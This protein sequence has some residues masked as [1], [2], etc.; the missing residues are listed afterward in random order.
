MKNETLVIGAT[1]KTDRY[2]YRAIKN[3]RSKNYKVKAIGVTKGA[4]DDVVINT[5][6]LNFETIDTVTLYI[7]PQIQK[8]YYEYILNL[9]PN[10]VIFNPGT[11]NFEFEQLLIEND[12]QVEVACTLVLLATNQY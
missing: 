6:K 3:L 7:N 10:R 2:A 9:K 11:E 1:T 8:E 5:Q 4:I 12:I